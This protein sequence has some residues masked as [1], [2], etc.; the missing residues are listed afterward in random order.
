MK[1]QVSNLWYRYEKSGHDILRNVSHTFEQGSFW[2]IF[3]PNGSGKTS[4]LKIMGGI[5]PTENLLRGSVSTEVLWKNRRDLAKN[6]A[7]IPGSLHTE[8]SLT[9]KEFC[10]HARYAHE[11]FWKKPSSKDHKIVNDTLERLALQ[12]IANIPLIELSSGQIQLALIARGIAQEPNAL[13][14]DECISNLDLNFQ[15]KIFSLLKKLNEEGMTIIMVCHD[16]NLASEFIPQALWLK[17]GEVYKAGSLENTFTTETI[18]ALYPST[19]LTVDRN[20]LSGKPK[21]FYK[22]HV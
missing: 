16:L 8:F 18:G 14:L 13:L 10:M 2:G 12:S 20:P 4:L 17:Y 7:Y 9:V 6:L 15:L 11:D 19:S 5:L 22:S 3:G 1:I 21:I